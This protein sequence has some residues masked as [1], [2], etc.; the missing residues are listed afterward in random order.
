MKRRDAALVESIRICARRAETF[1]DPGLS[2][3]VIAIGVGRIVQRLRTPS[4][5]CRTVRAE[6]DQMPHQSRIVARRRDMQSR[7]AGV[8]VVLNLRQEVPV[9]GLGGR[10][11]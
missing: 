6:F 10:S 7:V 2:P 1:D 4:V 11:D 8:E 3:R 9:R 5:P